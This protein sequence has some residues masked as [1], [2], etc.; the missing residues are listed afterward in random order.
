MA[1]VTLFDNGFLTRISRIS[2]MRENWAVHKFL[3]Q[4]E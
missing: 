1:V 3:L 2:A 4:N